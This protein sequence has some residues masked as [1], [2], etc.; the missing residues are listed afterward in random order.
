MSLFFSLSFQT[1]SFGSLTLTHTN[2]H[3]ALAHTHDAYGCILKSTY[4]RYTTGPMLIYCE[5]QNKEEK[6]SVYNK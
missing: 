5:T 3:I 2:T 1:G 6:Q 4:A